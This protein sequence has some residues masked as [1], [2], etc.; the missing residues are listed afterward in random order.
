[1]NKCSNCGGKGHNNRTC[2]APDIMDIIRIERKIKFPLPGTLAYYLVDDDSLHINFYG[3]EMEDEWDTMAEA[4]AAQKVIPKPTYVVARRKTPPE[5]FDPYM[6][7]IPEQ[8]TD[9]ITD[10]RRKKIE[11]ISWRCNKKTEMVTMFFR[12]EEIVNE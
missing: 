4:R 2:D 12:M 10:N 5:S 6:I 9:F 8:I 1:M 11:T 3:A 7:Q